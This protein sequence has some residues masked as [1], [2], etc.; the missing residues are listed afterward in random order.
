MRLE[1]GVSF[2]FLVKKDAL[3]GL[4]AVQPNVV[5]VVVQL[6]GFI[7]CDRRDARRGFETLV[8]KRIH[9]DPIVSWR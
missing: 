6:F 3:K 7:S 9:F 2:E 4:R 8:D 1:R 5:L